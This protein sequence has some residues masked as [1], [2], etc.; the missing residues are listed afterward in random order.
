MDIYRFHLGNIISRKSNTAFPIR[1]FI[2]SII[3]AMLLG[4][5]T[6]ME[7]GGRDLSALESCTYP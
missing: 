7:K 5:L 1:T 4:I 6:S 3:G 2:I